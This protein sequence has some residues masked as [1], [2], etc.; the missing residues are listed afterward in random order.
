MK[1]RC[2]KCS[3]RA[4]AGLYCEGC[5][6]RARERQRQVTAIYSE[7]GGWRKLPI[8]RDAAKAFPTD[9]HIDAWAIKTLAAI[10]RAKKGT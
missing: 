1:R 8:Y 4:T 10:E 9:A 5:W 7:P 6:Q 3:R 2:L